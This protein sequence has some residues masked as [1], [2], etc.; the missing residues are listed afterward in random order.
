MAGDWIKLEHATPQKPEVFRIADALQIDADAVVGKLARIWIW[1]DQQTYAGRFKRNAESNAGTVTK[2]A[3]PVVTRSLIDRL[4][5]TEGFA[6]AMHSVGWLEEDEDGLTFP[7]FDKHTGQ[8]AK[9]RA[10]TARRAKKHRSKSNGDR[11]AGSN[12]DRNADRNADTV[13]KSAPREEKRREDTPSLSPPRGSEDRE[14][15]EKGKKPEWTHSFE[16][17]WSL[18]LKIRDHLCRHRSAD[19]EA[20]LNQV[21]Q[22][23]RWANAIVEQVIPQFPGEPGRAW[24][25]F[26]DMR[27]TECRDRFKVAWAHVSR[28]VL[29]Q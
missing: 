1:A 21:A 8:T 29:S 15:D 26:L 18:L 9:Q 5:G 28:E 19:R 16:H 12:D 2:S 13:T 22:I 3:T 10:L 11:N 20:W 17:A 14:V 24:R 6:D 23:P 7:D 27:A 25:K 4:A